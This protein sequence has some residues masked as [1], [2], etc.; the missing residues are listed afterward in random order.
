MKIN[1]VMSHSKL[2][3][4][5]STMRSRTQPM[6]DTSRPSVRLGNLLTA[7]TVVLLLIAAAKGCWWV[8]EQPAS[9][10]MERHVLFQKL[11][12]LVTVRKLSI[13]MSHYGA[14]THKPTILYSSSLISTSNYQKPF[15]IS[16]TLILL[17]DVKGS[18]VA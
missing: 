7:R 1:R 16:V 13:R 4:R 6:G 12:R 5:G 17:R 11:L 3:S 8:C 18:H 14:P 10:L 15:L 9:S 2:R